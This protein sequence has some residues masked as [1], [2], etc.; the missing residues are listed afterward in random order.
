MSTTPTPTPAPSKVQSI[1]TIIDAAL[2]GLSLL[3]VV[4]APAGLADVFL[5]ILR[6]GLDAYQ[7]ETGQPLDLT[8]IPM[9][10]LVP[11]TPPTGTITQ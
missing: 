5:N 8:K 1:L 6:G 4:G 9:E 3:P 2:Q 7:A 10:A 11:T